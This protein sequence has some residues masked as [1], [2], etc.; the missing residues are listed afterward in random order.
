MELPNKQ[1]ELRRI[2]CPQIIFATQPEGYPFE[3]SSRLKVELLMSL[4]S[5]RFFNKFRLKY[6]L[7][8]LFVFLITIGFLGLV[9]KSMKTADSSPIPI[10][11]V[12]ALSGEQ[13]EVVAGEEMVHGVQMYVDMVNH[14]GGINGHPLKLL[15]FDDRADEKVAEQRAP[16]IAE[17]PAVVLLG[18]RSSASSEAGAKVYGAA[19]LPTITGTANTD[20]ITL[21]NPYYFR[22]TYTRSSLNT[23]IGVYT[24]IVLKL[25][26]ATV[27]EYEKYGK[28]LAQ[29]F[30]TAFTQ[31]GGK[32]N[33]KLTIDP[34]PQQRDQSIQKIVDNLAA[35]H[36]PGV[37]YFSL[38]DEK[39]AE[40]LLVAL[41][42][43]GLKLPIML[44]QA[45]S[46]E[47]FAKRFENYPEERQQPGFFTDGLYATAPLLFDSAGVDAQEFAETYQKRYGKSPSYVGTKY[48]EAAILAIDAIRNA[49]LE[50]TANSRDRDRE[51]VYAALKQIN[52]RPQVMSRGLTGPLYFN[53]ARSSDQPA[54]VGQFHN[55]RLLSAPQQFTPLTHAEQVDLPRELQAENV[56][57]AGN[58]YYWRQRVVYTGID[59]N[60]LSRIDQSKS[61][62]MIN[63]N[64]WLRYSG[65]DKP[66]AIQFPD[67]VANSLNP[68]AP[69]FDPKTPLKARSVEGLNYRLF[70]VAGEFKNS[71]DL[72]DYPFDAQKMTVRFL[73]TH[74]SSERLIYVI[75]TLGLK[76]LRTDLAQ[77]KRAFSGL[78]LWQFKDM[79]YAQDVLRSTSTQG[80]PAL[81]ESNVQTDYPGFSLA[82]RFQRHALIFLIKNLLPLGLLTL[83]A[84][85]TLYFSY[86]LSVPR[87]LATCSVLLSGIVLLLSINNQLPEVGYTI[88]LEYTFYVFFF[89]CVFSI[90]ITTLGEKLEKAGRKEAVQR[91]NLFA[92]V[93]FPIVVLLCV[94]AFGTN[95][96]QSL[97]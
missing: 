86:S 27:I 66:L 17:S 35:D 13:A 15:T 64:I 10:A 39:E 83:V 76:L 51:K 47:D 28:K 45:L 50:T 62:F 16:E 42:R 95:Y 11:V 90:V 4:L 88:A 61:S 68:T 81:F 63:F 57:Q 36:N 7:L 41:K 40:K 53:A 71:F 55:L 44:G 96:S 92:R 31:S 52:N 1:Q 58:Q 85:S 93:F 79:Q 19:H 33:S 97:M 94:A 34:N 59:V 18:H 3:K 60:K 84:Y 43:R 69:I 20:T 21:N 32:I 75:D 14:K 38:R 72:R 22:N 12:A 5:I 91:L 8:A 6:W 87:I 25:N 78:Q 80:D 65:D 74:L 82:M 77:Q 24:N 73:N 67:A 56:V 2:P 30:E 54:R 9:S 89:L 26:T 29:E 49:N 48:Y 23:V 70:Q 37:V 46:R